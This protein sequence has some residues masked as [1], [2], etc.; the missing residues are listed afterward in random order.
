MHDLIKI[1]DKTRPYTTSHFLQIFFVSIKKLT[2]PCIWW[3]TCKK[4]NNQTLHLQIYIKCIRN[5]NE[6]NKGNWEQNMLYNKSQQ[7]FDRKRISLLKVSYLACKCVFHR[8]DHN[9]NGDPIELNFESL[10]FKKNRIYHWIELNEQM[11]KIGLFV[12]FSCLLPELAIKMSKMTLFSY[13]LLMA[14]INQSQFKQNI[15]VQIFK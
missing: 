8:L 6:T 9:A 1:Q 13:F 2:R 10:K 14:A 7:I 12:Q 11:G 4:S 5:I 15:Q 3:N